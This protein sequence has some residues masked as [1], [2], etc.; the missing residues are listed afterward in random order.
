MKFVRLINEQ[1]IFIEDAFVE[2]LT[3][4]TIETPCPQGFY[5]P[6]WDGEVV[7][8][9]IEMEEEIDSGFNHEEVDEDF[10]HKEV[11]TIRTE[12]GQWVES[13]T[14]EE[15]QALKDSVP[16][17][18]EEVDVNVLRQDVDE[19]QETVLHDI[20]QP[21][22]FRSMMM[23]VRKILKQSEMT[24]EELLELIDVYDEF[25]MGLEV[26]VGD[27]YKYQ[28]NLYE[29]IQEHTTQWTPDTVPALFNKVIPKGVIPEWE[30]PTGSQNAYKIGDTVTYKGSTYVS[31]IEGNTTVPDGD[32]PHNRYWTLT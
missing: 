6:K 18:I 8:E 23:A 4:L 29:V 13:L 5:L 27:Y 14:E 16:D 1:G 9:A 30:Q 7:Y 24:D 20:P 22:M 2:E 32:T 21:M 28:D 15:I 25:E 3:E 12:V 17:P 11:Q 10:T 26:I 31:K 19:L